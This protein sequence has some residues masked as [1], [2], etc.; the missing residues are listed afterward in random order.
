M[1]FYA[2]VALRSPDGYALGTFSVLGFE[3]RKVTDAE[4]A[5]LSDL[6]ALVIDELELR[7]EAKRLRGELQGSNEVR[8][9]PPA[10]LESPPLSE[11]V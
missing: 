1:Q 9:L 4:V 8:T 3:P 11:A 10:P 7:L 6:A 5:T 2:S